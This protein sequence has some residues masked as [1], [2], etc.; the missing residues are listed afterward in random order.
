[1]P[2]DYQDISDSLMPLTKTVARATD[3]RFEVELDA[4]ATAAL[5][6]M[7]RVG[8]ADECFDESSPY[9]PLVRQAVVFYTKAHFGGDNPNAEM[10]FWRESYQQTVTD[11]LNSAANSHAAEDDDEVE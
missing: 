10:G 9:Y 7:S 1:M 4:M 5:A 11:L 8:V 6:D 2:I 3:Q